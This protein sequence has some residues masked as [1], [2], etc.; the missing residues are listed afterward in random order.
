MLLIANEVFPDT[1]NWTKKDPGVIY[2]MMSRFPTRP[3]H[4]YYMHALR[5]Q[6]SVRIPHDNYVG[7][8]DWRAYTAR[9]GINTSHI[10]DNN[11]NQGPKMNE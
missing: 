5:N 1:V 7:Y 10:R 8:H 2:F 4:D 9:K 6:V 3:V 11:P